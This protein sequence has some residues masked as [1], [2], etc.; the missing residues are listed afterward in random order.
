MKTIYN[1]PLNKDTDIVTIFY[2]DDVND[3]HISQ[4]VENKTQ[5]GLVVL[6]IEQSLSPEKLRELA[7]RL[8]KTEA[9]F[10]EMFD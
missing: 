2:K 3:I 4:R 9:D 1:Y 7:D 5:F 6:D 8:E 10:K